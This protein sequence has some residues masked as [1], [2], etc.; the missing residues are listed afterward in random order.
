MAH[1]AVGSGSSGWESQQRWGVAAAGREWRAVGSHSSGWEWRVR[2]WSLARRC[3]TAL[4]NTLISLACTA[5]PPASASP[6]AGPIIRVTHDGRYTTFLRSVAAVAAAAAA[7][8][9]VASVASAGSGGA[10]S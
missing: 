10:R 3:R 7:A 2:G 9:S 1:T 5:S 4:S 8:A 6:R